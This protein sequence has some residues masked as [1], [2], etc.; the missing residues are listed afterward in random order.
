MNVGDLPMLVSLHGIDGSGKTTI[1]N[2]VEDKLKSFGY[3]VLI[4]RN[5]SSQLGEYLKEILLYHEVIPLESRLL[6]YAAEYY[7]RLEGIKRALD[8]NYIVIAD[9]YILDAFVYTLARLKVGSS[10]AV[11]DESYIIDLLKTVYRPFPKP[12][13]SFILDLDPHV[14]RDRIQKKYGRRLDLTEQNIEIQYRARELFL[15]L[16]HE[17]SA[18]FAIRHYII[19][20]SNKTSN[21]VVEIIVSKIIEM[22]KKLIKQAGC[23]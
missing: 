11:T 18:F 1:S 2:L 5:L 8:N 4:T 7:S 6:L 20:V 10:I 13:L 16:V 19:D 14:A 9:R 12:S 17:N 3:N 22:Q 23:L 15:S 21:E